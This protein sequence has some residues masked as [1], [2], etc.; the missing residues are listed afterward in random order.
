MFFYCMMSDRLLLRYEMPGA[1]LLGMVNCRIC[2]T[3]WNAYRYR[4][5]PNHCAKPDVYCLYLVSET[6]LLIIQI[7]I[8]DEFTK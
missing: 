8:T 5:H 4:V 1:Q 3:C 2:H 7:I 6:N